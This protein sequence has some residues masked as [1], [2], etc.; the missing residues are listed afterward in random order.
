MANAA[1][2][3]SASKAL[4]SSALSSNESNKSLVEEW[5]SQVKGGATEVTDLKVS[6]Q[7]PESTKT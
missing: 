4:G 1:Y 3:D 6:W 2:L 5:I 7:I